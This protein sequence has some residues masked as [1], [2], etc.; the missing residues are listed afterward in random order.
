MTGDVPRRRFL[1]TGAAAL[2]A[3]G[4]A[5][6]LGANDRVGVGF[7]GVGNRGSGLAPCELGLALLAERRG[8]LGEVRGR[9]ATFPHIS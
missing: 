4:Y 6:V 7:I 3:A 2:T 1:T 5:R 9:R 8:A